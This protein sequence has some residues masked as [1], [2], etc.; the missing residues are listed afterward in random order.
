MPTK[1]FGEMMM[2]PQMMGEDL[3]GLGIDPNNPMDRIKWINQVAKDRKNIQMQ[4]FLRMLRGGIEAAP[5][6]IPFEEGVYNRI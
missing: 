3:T 5:E 4:E 2:N 6:Q 1:D